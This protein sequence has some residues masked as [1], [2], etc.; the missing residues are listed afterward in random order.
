LVR[1]LSVIFAGAA[2]LLTAVSPELVKVLG[3]PE[4]Q[5][6]KWYVPWIALSYALFGGTLLITTMISISKKTI[7]LP[8]L[9]LTG[10][11]LKI[12]LAFAMISAFGGI[13]APLS[14]VVAYV[15]ELGF[16]YYVAQKL[17]PTPHDTRKLC[18]LLVL[19]L[20]CI[21]AIILCNLLP[22]YLSITGRGALLA[23]F[24][25]LLLTTGIMTRGEVSGLFKVIGRRGAWLRVPVRKAEK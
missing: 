18:L 12:G 25:A 8:L 10:G 17:Y 5:S 3:P 14:T 15:V 16:A 7:V 23:A 20:G 21:I 19:T 24:P 1:V 22:F 4:Y 6:A 11:C 2:V 9:H 13:G